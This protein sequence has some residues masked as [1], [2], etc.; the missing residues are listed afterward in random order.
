LRMGRRI[1][2]GIESLDGKGQ[3]H[4]RR[5]AFSSQPSAS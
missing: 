2:F 3:A 4:G 1:D 5:S